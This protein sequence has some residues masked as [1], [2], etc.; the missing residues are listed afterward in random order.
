MK[1]AVV[2][3]NWNGEQMLRQFLPSV[4]EHSVLPKALGEAVVY[5]ADN[6]S[7]DGSLALL[8]AEFPTV[9]TI[10]F[11][12][13]YGFADGYNKAFEQIDA[14][15]AVLLNSDVEVTAGWLAPLVEYMDAHPQVGAC[16]PKLM[17]YH[18]KDEFEY[19]GAMGGYLDRYGYPYCRGRIFDTIEND[20]GQYDTDVPLLWATGACLMARLA[21]YKEVGGLD[22]RFFAHME[23][24]DLC[25]RLRCR[26]HEVRSVASS[27][28]YRVGGATLNAGHPRK[29]FLNFRNNLLMLYKNLPAKELRGVLF[30]R[31]LL[32][33]VAAAMFLVKGEWGNVKAVFRARREYRKLKTEFQASRED[34]LRKSVAMDVPER[35]RYSILWKYH[36]RRCHTFDEL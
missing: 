31:G 23:E 24:I 21:T 5:V 33:Y 36:V 14:E 10:V 9:R 7:T 27:V 22:G 18:Q 11:E 6:G 34:N 1:V 15:Y 35:A 16:Q 26:G 25:W 4:V 17:A 19:A 29:T 13:N 2:I 12:E 28:V 3:L 30:V 32:D 20:H 8:K